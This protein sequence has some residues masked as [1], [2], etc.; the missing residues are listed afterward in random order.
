VAAPDNDPL[1]E[2]PASIAAAISRYGTREREYG[3]ALGLFPALP[4]AS[5]VD[6]LKSV[7]LAEQRV[8]AAIQAYLREAHDGR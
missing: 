2:L 1:G 6:R 3:L 5:R 7:A 8:V 4:E